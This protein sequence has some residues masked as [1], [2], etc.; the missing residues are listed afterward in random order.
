MIFNGNSNLWSRANATQKMHVYLL[1]HKT[2][3]N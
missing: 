1:Q 3:E 2:D